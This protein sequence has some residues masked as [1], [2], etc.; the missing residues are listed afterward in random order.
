M[1][2]NLFYEDGIRKISVPEKYR[3]KEGYNLIL[4]SGLIKKTNYIEWKKK[5]CSYGSSV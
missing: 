4:E 1:I 3:T 5:Y 2:D